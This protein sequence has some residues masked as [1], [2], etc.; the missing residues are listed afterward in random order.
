MTKSAVVF[1]RMSE[2]ERAQME[3]VA[4]AYGMTKSEFVRAFTQY[5]AEYRPRLIIEPK[6]SRNGEDK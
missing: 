4:S 6:P 1:L 2:K 3:S 5:V